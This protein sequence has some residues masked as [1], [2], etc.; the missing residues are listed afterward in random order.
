MV[1]M[2]EKFV[3][4]Y[5]RLSM[6]D[7]DVVSD[8]AKE[9]SDSILHQRNLIAG[10]LRDKK[11]YPK[12]QVIEFV[13]D[14]YSGT[15]FERPAV[16]RMLSM[17]RE[18][19]ICCVIVKDI[20]RFGRN[21]L[22][23]GDYLEQI[24][25]FMGVRF[26][27]VSDGYD[28]ADYEGTTGGIEIAFKSFLYD[29]Y[30]KDLSVKMC[31]ALK[32]RRKRGDFIGPRPPFGYRFSDNKKVLAVD[33]EAAEYVRKIFGLAC[34]GYSTGKIAIKL[35]EEHVPTPGQYKNRDRQ[36]YHVLGG[37]GYWSSKMVLNI[38]ENRVYLGTVVNGKYKVTKVG[39]KQFKRVADEDRICVS[40]KHEAIVTEQ[41]FRKAAEV[42]KY[43]GCQKGKEHNAKQE[44][45]LL[46]KLRCGNCKK[47]LI[48]ITCTKEPCFLCEREKYKE[49]SGCFGGRVKEQEAEEIV[50]KFINQRL[51]QQR[52]GQE[53]REQ[54]TQGQGGG[55]SQFG[56]VQK[57]NRDGVLEKKLDALKVEKQYLYE[58]FKLGQL[59]KE[60]YL[61]KVG[62]LREGERTIGEEIRRVKK[63][64]NRDSVRQDEED[65][66][67]EIKSLTRE[68]VEQMVVAVYVDGEGELR[69]VWKK[70]K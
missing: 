19:K 1:N 56:I 47:C 43:R 8:S 45:I 30:S 50:L 18:G 64:K 61:N 23:V 3:A 21:Y 41:E 59:E 16:K 68:I 40:G 42:I 70:D 63:E 34:N 54:E 58:Q 60:A 6:E 14:G 55:S 36:Q 38:L 29:M 22:E 2:E 37:D 69:V 66:R 12:A 62:V 17:I 24:F 10:Y 51:E 44:S 4:E 26:I 31:S 11:L 5:L 20:S 48:R 15:N 27:A 28:S 65:C 33:E 39:G 32:I 9:E 46:G 52:K 13:D 67:K 53:C 35:N 25:P 57:K 49:G 7:G